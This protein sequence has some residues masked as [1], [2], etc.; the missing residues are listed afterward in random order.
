MFTAE[1]QRAQR[2]KFFNCPAV[3]GTIEKLRY[4]PAGFQTEAF[5]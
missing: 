5:V 2:G 3:S 1:A 4:P